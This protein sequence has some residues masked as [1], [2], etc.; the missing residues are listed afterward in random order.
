MDRVETP[1][2][3]SVD[4]PLTSGWKA[5]LK[6]PR[7]ADADVPQCNDRSGAPPRGDGTDRLL[8]TWAARSRTRQLTLYPDA[9]AARAAVRAL[10]SYYRGCPSTGFGELPWRVRT[11]VRSVA[12]ARWEVRQRLADA[13]GVFGGALVQVVQVG[14]A[15]LLDVAGTLTEGRPWVDI[16]RSIAEDQVTWSA[17]VVAAMEE[18]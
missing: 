17:G 4:F 18:L 9:A 16:A 6:E 10:L 2:V 7:H 3:L 12:P 14:R 1:D 15:V 13:D 5:G 8:A 11:S